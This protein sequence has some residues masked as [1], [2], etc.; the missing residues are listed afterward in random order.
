MYDPWP[1]C[2]GSA[3][4]GGAASFAVV[5]APHVLERLGGGW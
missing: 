4:I 3:A 1:R 2:V 5:L